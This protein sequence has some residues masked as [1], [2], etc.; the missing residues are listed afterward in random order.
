MSGTRK[1]D[2]F[3]FAHL[4]GDDVIKVEIVAATEYTARIYCLKT[5]AQPSD[6]KEWYIELES[7]TPLAAFYNAEVRDALSKLDGTT[8]SAISA[9]SGFREELDDLGGIDDD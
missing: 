8:S 5:L 6:D 4:R 2:E 7:V 1:G 9:A 3:I